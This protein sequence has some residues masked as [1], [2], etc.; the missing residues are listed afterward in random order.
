[1]EETTAVAE[2]YEELCRNFS[3]AVPR[4][5]NFGYDIIDTW[6]EKD[7]NKL[8]MIW[9]NQE[10]CEKKFSFRDLKNS[11]TRQP[12]SLSSTGS[13]RGIKSSSYCPGSPSGGCS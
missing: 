11:Q 4:N 6:A 10:G 13:R 5:F 8:A 9:V 7:R 1:M 3:I 12:T 2:D